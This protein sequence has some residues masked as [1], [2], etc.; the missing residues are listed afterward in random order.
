MKFLTAHCLQRK[1][2]LIHHS[3]IR[4]KPNAFLLYLL[5]PKH[6]IIKILSLKFRKRPLEVA[7]Q[8]C[9]HL[10]LTEKSLKK[11]SQGRQYVFLSPPLP[12]SVS[13]FL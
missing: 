12:S 13:V 10:F 8:T 7:F 1:F 9:N 3:N 2:W 4:N 5:Q 11:K 6:K